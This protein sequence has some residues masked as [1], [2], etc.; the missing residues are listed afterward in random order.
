M[1]LQ[2]NN[3]LGFGDR[4]I[5][6]YTNTDGSDAGDISYNFPLNRQNGSLSLAAGINDT[7]I[8][9]SPFDDLNI[10]GDSYY[11]DF[12]LRQPIIFKP[13]QELALGITFSYQESQ[14]EI[15]GQDFPFIP[16][17]NPK[18]ETSISAIRF[19][20]DFVQRN[21]T[22]LLALRSQF[23][24]GLD[25]FD[26]TVEDNAA[27]SRF[28]AWRGQAQYVKLLAPDTVLILRSDIQIADDNLLSQERFSLGGFNSVRGYRQNLL[29]ADNGIFTSAEVKLPIASFAGNKAIVQFVPFVD[30]GTVWNV[31]VE[32]DL[33]PDTIVA[34]GAGL[35]FSFNDS[36]NARI[37]WGIPLVDPDTDSDTLQENGIY[38]S[39]D[40]QL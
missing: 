7:E 35:Q 36:L 8:V 40:Y 18:G 15:L 2:E 38:F 37:D 32:G 1:T 33:E 39:I 17:I 5:L 22:D 24:I 30:F 9:E 19:F 25:I 21:P 28:I 11:L 31:E 34:L 10:Q 23:S 16:N 29:L 20:Q 3:F 4:L 6:K 27:D 12:S 26:S 14:T 13:T